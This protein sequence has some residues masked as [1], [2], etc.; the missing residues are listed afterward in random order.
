MRTVKDVE[1]DTRIGV[2]LDQSKTNIHKVI[3]LLENDN[4]HERESL[5]KVIEKIDYAREILG[6][7]KRDFY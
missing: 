3:V 5:Y 1:D 2:Y 4:Q 7:R 6:I